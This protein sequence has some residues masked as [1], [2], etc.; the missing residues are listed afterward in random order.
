MK[1]EHLINSLPFEI[2]SSIVSQLDSLSSISEKLDTIREWIHFNQNISH[3]KRLEWHKPVLD[4]AQKNDLLEDE[5]KSYSNM[6][7]IYDR[8]GDFD[9]SLAA[10]RKAKDIWSKLSVESSAYHH[11]LIISHCD[12]AVTYRLKN[13]IDKAFEIL[14]DGYEI[15]KKNGFNHDGALII[16]YSDLGVIYKEIQDY[17]A[18][19]DMFHESLSLIK[20]SN[21]LDQY[22]EN[23]IICHINIGNIY[24]KTKN[25]EAAYVEFSKAADYAL[26]YDKYYQHF[27]ISYIN[28]GQTLFSMKK[29]KKSIQIYNKALPKCKTSGSDMD[30]GFLYV[31]IAESYLEMDDFKNYKQSISKGK[32]LVE[33]AAYPNDVIFLNRVISSYYIKI[34]K[35]K[36]AA[37]LLNKSL[38]LSRKCKLE[39]LKLD[40]CKTL[41]KVYENMKE[42]NIA[43]Q[44]SKY[45]IK[46]KEQIDSKMQVHFLNEKQRS[47]NKMQEEVTRLKEDEERKRLKLDIDYKRR[48][49]SSKKLISASNR[50]FMQKL[51]NSLENIS[52]KDGEVGSIINVCKKQID[53]SSNWKEFL[54]TYEELNPSFMQVI[55]RFSD[56]LSTTEIRVCS[57]IHLGMD[58]YEIAELMFISKR[59]IEQHRYRIKKKLKINVNL[60]EFLFSIC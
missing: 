2:P 12:I 55:S 11:N 37:T 58:N 60:T 59:S 25:L 20:D 6:A 10:N 56:I 23:I 42:D 32:E 29:Y 44:Y 43:L 3:D 38:E 51:L 39:K 50:D 27:I 46:I 14:H 1:A 52:N 8:M 28:L 36:R 22:K 19:L 53:S 15:F 34:K 47:L 24:T 7:K 13:S 4:L 35:F 57:L 21:N 18:A 33:K 31:N 30:L 26:K 40:L 16:L 41:I 49:I 9:S 17:P 48:E 5:A 45:Y 54:K